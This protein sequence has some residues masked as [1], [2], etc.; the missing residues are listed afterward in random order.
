ME[1]PFSLSLNL[2]SLSRAEVTVSVLGDTGQACSLCS[3]QDS[4]G[5]LLR[6][7]GGSFLSLG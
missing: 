5:K 7:S 1:L 3:C 6:L 4:S 2:P